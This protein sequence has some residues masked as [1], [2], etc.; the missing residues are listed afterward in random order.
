MA[1][2]RV[3]RSHSKS[4]A[5]G[6]S[7]RVAAHEAEGGISTGPNKTDAPRLHRGGGGGSVG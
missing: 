1:S 4:A 7:S 3:A 2:S 6:S 5:A